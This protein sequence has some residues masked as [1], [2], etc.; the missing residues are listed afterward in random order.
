MPKCWEHGANRARC[1]PASDGTSRRARRTRWPQWVTMRQDGSRG[2]GE[3]IGG[4][5]GRSREGGGRATNVGIVP[6]ACRWAASA[7]SHQGS[8]DSVREAAGVL[9]IG[10]VGMRLLTNDDP[11]TNISSEEAV[12]RKHDSLDASTA[13]PIALLELEMVMQL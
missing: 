4:R 8:V 12:K 7:R 9:N 11:T 1:C 6:Y 2:I 13:S 5:G 3:E 10:S